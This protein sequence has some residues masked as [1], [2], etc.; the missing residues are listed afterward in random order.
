MQVEA[1]GRYSLYSSGLRFLETGMIMDFFQLSGIICESR[2]LWKMSTHAQANS[3]AK[4]FRERPSDLFDFE[5]FENLNIISQSH[6]WLK[7]KSPKV[8]IA[9]YI[10]TVIRVNIQPTVEYL[11]FSTYTV[12]ILLLL[13]VILVIHST[14]D[15][16]LFE[17]LLKSLS[18]TSP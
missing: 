15:H 4:V 6:L 11:Y 7:Y 16:N 12:C 17:L 13:G 18:T 5:T 14:S 8:I 1:T 2:N 3:S 9:L 10:T